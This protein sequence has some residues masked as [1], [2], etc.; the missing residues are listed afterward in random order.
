MAAEDDGFFS[1]WSQRKA[2]VRRGETV[3]AEPETVVPSVP[4]PVELAHAEPAGTEPS[5]AVELPPPTL[6][7]AQALTPEADFRPFVRKDVLPE[8]RNT[9]MKKLFT[10]PHFNVMDGLD[11]YIDD[12]SQPNPLP[13]AMAKQLVGAQFLKL[14]DQPEAPAQ[15]SP[16]PEATPPEPVPP[17]NSEPIPPETP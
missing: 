6:E 15:P 17:S 12:Y 5:P 1:R 16:T 2:Q 7:D 8:V 13:L 4:P 14:F 9:A 11:I 3:K 10:D